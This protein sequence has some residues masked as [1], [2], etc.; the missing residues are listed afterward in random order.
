M[1]IDFLGWLQGPGVPFPSRSG[2]K[3]A[4]R[5]LGACAWRWSYLIIS[6]VLQPTHRACNLSCRTHLVHLWDNVGPLYG[7]G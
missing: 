6:E 4:G 7:K 2:P 3:W 1:I 5:S